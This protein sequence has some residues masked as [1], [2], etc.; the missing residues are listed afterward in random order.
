M[1]ASGL[2]YRAGPLVWAA[3]IGAT[4]VVLF[5]FQKILWLVV[6]FILAL[7]IYYVLMPLKLQLLLRGVSHDRAAAWVSLLAFGVFLAGAVFAFPA[8]FGEA[9][10]WQDSAM[11]YLGGGIRLLAGAMSDLEQRFGFIAQSSAREMLEA[12]LGGFFE[13]FAEKYLPGLVMGI[14]AWSPSLMLAPF[15]AFFMLRDGWRFRRFLLRAVP[16]AYFERSLYVM[17]EVDRTARQYFVGLLQLTL[18]DT[19]C[20]AAGLWA[21]GISGA[22]TLGLVTAVLAWVPY[23]GSIIGCLLVV[24][25][26][27]TDFPGQPGVAYAAIALFLFVRLLDDFVFMPLTVGKSLKMHPLLTVLMIFVGG[28]VAGVPGL[29]LVLPVLGVLMVI[30]ETLGLLLT[31]PRLRARHAHEQAL[32]QQLVTRDL[33]LPPC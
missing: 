32:R 5:L 27:A 24:L 6:P 11:R 21:I 9:I 8:L 2:P 25:V 17:D 7:I 22:L 16:N 23:I 12:Q 30:G 13:H 20:L 14:V 10:A 33:P 4:C 29:M 28:A 19:V 15:L 26:A 3:N 31:D 1:T 18:L